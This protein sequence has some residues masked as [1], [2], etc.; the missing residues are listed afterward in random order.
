MKRPRIDVNLGELD[1]LLEQ[2]QQAPLSEPDCNK[3]KT[4]LH[5]LVELLIAKRHTEKTSAVVGTARRRR[6][7]GVLRLGG[8]ADQRA[9][10]Q[11]GVGLRRSHESGGAASE[12][13]ARRCVPGMSQGK[14]VCAK[15][16]PAAGT[17]R[18]T[19]AAGSNRLRS[20]TDALQCLRASVHGA[21]AGGR[22]H[23]PAGIAAHL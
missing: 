19:S 4:T 5:T 13:K 15:G 9:R 10:A 12:S 16:A 11:P 18:G 2:A 17:H 1:Q 8:E 23:L 6:R 20:G 22:E 7:S 21:G 14:S 3:I